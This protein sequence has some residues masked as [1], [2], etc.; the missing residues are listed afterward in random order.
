M[1]GGP[2]RLRRRRAV[3]AG[4]RSGRWR[5]PLSGGV[6]ALILGA[7]CLAPLAPSALAPLGGSSTSN[8]APTTE[9]DAPNATNTG[10]AGTAPQVVT[11]AV[12]PALPVVAV[13]PVPAPSVPTPTPVP[14]PSVVPTLTP[15]GQ[16]MLAGIKADRTA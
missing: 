6:L 9:P 5:L 11:N 12:A 4:R 15:A 7:A 3:H 2:M 8:A 1:L 13:P 10:N 16:A 14:V